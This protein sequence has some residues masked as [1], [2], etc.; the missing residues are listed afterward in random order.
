MPLMLSPLI[1]F[2]DPPVPDEVEDA[3]SDIDPEM[4]EVESPEETMTSPEF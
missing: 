3:T 2:T 4:S 1:I